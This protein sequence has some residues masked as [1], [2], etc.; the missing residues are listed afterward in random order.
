MNF[1]KYQIKQ[2]N[3]AKVII[4]TKKRSNG[5]AYLE[6]EMQIIYFPFST[7]AFG[8][9]AFI[10]YLLFSKNRNIDYTFTSQTIINGIIGF[11]KKLGFFKN[12]HI[13][14]RESNSIFELLSG[15]KLKIYSLFYSLGYSKS[16]LVICQTEYMKNKLISALP[17]LTKKI[18]LAVVPNPIDFLDIEY[19][20]KEIV[21]GL[22]D[23]SYLVAAGRLV[24]AKGFDI[25]IDAF[26]N[27]SNKFP[28]MELIILG[29][30]RDKEILEHKSKVLG[31]ENRISFPGY[32]SNVYPFFKEAEACI[33]SS[34]IEGFPNVLLQMMSQNTKAI[35]TLSAGGIEN[36]EGIFT[37]I[38]NNSIELENT[39][40]NCLNSETD[41]NRNVFDEYLKKRTQDA[42]YNNIMNHVKV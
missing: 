11:S 41:K 24:P 38:P 42:F 26:K 35:C 1:A 8:I 36:I 18:N 2:G 25:L 9:L 16:T 32:V 33:V 28:D 22:K 20:T 6:K 3:A 15:L 23:K 27:I 14:L 10:P 39:I 17:K 12:T 37:C 21:P 7:Y 5:W 13:I 34:R 40:T 4:L 31:L 19:K 30:G 29:E